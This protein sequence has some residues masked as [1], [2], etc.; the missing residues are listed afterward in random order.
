MTMKALEQ[1]RELEN[2][3]E[4]AGGYVADPRTIKKNPKGE[5]DF[6]AIRRYCFERKISISDMTEEDYKNIGVCPPDLP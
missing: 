3:A 6:T 2:A 1:M 5:K 4:R